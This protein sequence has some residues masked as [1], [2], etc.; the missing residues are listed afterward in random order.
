MNRSTYLTEL[1]SKVKNKFEI[2]F[3]QEFPIVCSFYTAGH[4]KLLS[5][6]KINA[7]RTSRFITEKDI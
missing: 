1:N 3:K 2:L 4:L 6:T 5:I 7:T